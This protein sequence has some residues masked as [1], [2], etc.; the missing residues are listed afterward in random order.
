MIFHVIEEKVYVI[1]KRKNYV[2]IEFYLKKKIT[3]LF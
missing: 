2:T 3:F 1:F